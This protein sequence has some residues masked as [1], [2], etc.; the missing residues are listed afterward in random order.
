[1]NVPAI[2]LAA[3]GTNRHHDVA[4]ALTLAGARPSIVPLAELR[5]K[6]AVLDG[7]RLLVV[8]GG[9]SFA[10]ACGSGR[11]FALEL[12]DILGE[13]LAAHVGA[14]RPVLGI[15][16]GFQVLVR[17]GVLPGAGR[18][19]LAPNEAGGFV[20]RWVTLAPEASSPCVWTSALT[21]TIDCPVAHG[22][23]RFVAD[24][25]TRRAMRAAGQYA[26]TYVGVNPNG[27]M[28]AVAGI[29]DLTGL[30]LG[31]MPHPE[32]HVLDHQ[33]P[34]WRRGH[35]GG[36]GLPLFRAGVRHAEEL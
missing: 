31:L 35:R 29:T 28:D 6:P 16:N 32:N 30:V 17:L 25:P 10:D 20:C 22:E 15:C 13:G 7:A 21:E 5:A 14:G 8:A 27:S 3:P 34:R 23:G 11:L 18:A 24:V 12:H 33:H 26:L 9:F 36:S 2:V 4:H 1:V 19:T